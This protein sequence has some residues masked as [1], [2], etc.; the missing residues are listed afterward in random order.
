MLNTVYRLI[1]PRTF[2]ECYEDIDI[3]QD[4]IIRPTHFSICHADQRY[5]QGLRDPKILKQKLPMA[6]IH[7]SI[8]I[9]VKDNTNTFNKGDKVVM[10][11]NTPLETDDIISENYL[12]SSKFRSSGYDGFMQEVVQMNKNRVLKLPENIDLDVLAFTELISVATHAITRFEKFSHERRNRIGIWGDGNLSYILSLLLKIEMPE[13][14][15]YVFGK[16]TEKLNLYSFVEN[17]FLINEI[18][19]NLTVDH[20]FECTGGMG[21]EKSINQIINYIEPE[22][23]ISLLGVSENKVP[24]NTRIILEKGLR[25]FGSNRSGREDFEKSLSYLSENIFLIEYLENLVTNIV[26]VETLHDVDKAFILDKESSFGKT[27]MHWN[28]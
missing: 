25:L 24:L 1:S 13:T 4:V 11:P 22:G 6:L 14:E 5:Y 16:H 21:C 26:E 27:I 7:E 3:S 19:S 15:I 18:P 28:H 17:T 10:I 9:I 12:K 23:T 2:E 8:G 20:A